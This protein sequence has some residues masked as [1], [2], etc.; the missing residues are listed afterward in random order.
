MRGIILAFVLLISVSSVNALYEQ[1]DFYEASAKYHSPIIFVPG[2]MGSVLEDHNRWVSADELWPGG[3]QEDRSE[4]ALDDSGE[5]P[6]IEG[7]DI[8]AVRVLRDVFVFKDVYGGFFE[9]FDENTDYKY[10][11]QRG[12]VSY[13]GRAVFEHPYDFRLDTREHVTGANSLHEKVNDILKNTDSDKVI[14][15][16][17]SMGGLQAKMFA[18]RYPNKV[19]GVIFL[20]SPLNGAPRGFQ[21]LSEG[22]NFDATAL[23]SEAHVWEIGHN[24]PGPHHLMPKDPF[25]EKD[26][27]LISLEDT[28]TQGINYQRAQH[29]PYEFW[30]DLDRRGIKDPAAVTAELEKKY[31]GLSPKLVENTAQ[32]R[33]E[34]DSLS[35]PSDIRVEII[36]GTNQP[37]TQGYEIRDELMTISHTRGQVR[38]PFTFTVRRFDK[39]DTSSG[40]E[41]VPNYGFFWNRAKNTQSVDYGHMAMSTQTET[42][43]KVEEIVEDLNKDERD[44]KWVETIKSLAIMQL[45][46]INDNTMYDQQRYAD[47]LGDAYKAEAEKDDP[48]QERLGRLSG[49]IQ[50]SGKLAFFA[51]LLIGQRSTIQFIAED[52]G[53]YDRSNTDFK[54]WLALQSNE[55][56]DS[57]IG[58]V[59]PAR[60]TIKVDKQTFNGLMDGS[61]SVEDAYK[62]NKLKISGGLL[63][64][65]LL[66]VSQWLIRFTS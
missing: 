60:F 53:E 22:Y 45:N 30:E 16:A 35:I 63:E 4:L 66:W 44:Q 23:I 38:I 61:L 2:I 52:A 28:Y 24:W 50:G 62:A 40:D 34:F 36:H 29:I 8:K 65:M 15:V 42:L 43:T 18:A 25:V 13:I 47:N 21:S 59:K 49:D 1:G 33:R 12:D 37:T 56:V 26:G 27:N 57:G 5:K 41:T 9:Y 6:V 32:F 7:T 54:A 14:L 3:I 46:K 31:A 20:S 48:D 19:R 58:E 17:H 55:I 39:F 10:N 64:N 11:G 51:G